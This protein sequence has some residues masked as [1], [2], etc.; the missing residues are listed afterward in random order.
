MTKKMP[1]RNN[2]S[3]RVSSRRTSRAES[4]ATEVTL[5]LFVAGD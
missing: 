5:G 3:I 1:F 2:I 4:Y